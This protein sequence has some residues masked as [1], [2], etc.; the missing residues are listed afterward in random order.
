MFEVSWSELLIL[1]IVTLLLVG[2]KELPRFLSTLGRQLGVI[3]KHA[4][5]FRAVFEQAM[6]EAEMDS[7]QK[8]M[9]DIGDGVKK[10][11][12]DVTRS[13]DDTKA[14][15]RVDLNSNRAGKPLPP[16]ESPAEA[17]AASAAE[18]EAGPSAADDEVT[19]QPDAQPVADSSAAA[20]RPGETGRGAG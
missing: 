16:S 4:N 20:D 9:R 13:V 17:H 8:E 5:E 1:G 3:R 10:S 14:A 18:P 7:I 11:F 6:R 15:M 2:P 12:D 19:G